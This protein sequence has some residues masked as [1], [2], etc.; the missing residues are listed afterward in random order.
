MSVNGE[1]GL[2][3]TTILPV[4]VDAVGVL[5]SVAVMLSVVEAAF[6]GVPVNVQL[7][8]VSPA[9]TVPLLSTQVYGAVPPLTPMTPV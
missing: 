3:V 8:S 6:V 1:S 2:I 5:E 7:V 9:G 4:V